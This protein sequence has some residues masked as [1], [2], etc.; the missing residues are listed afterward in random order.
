VRGRAGEMVVTPNDWLHPVCE[1]FI[2]GA[3]EL[4]IPGGPDYNGA[5]QAGV[6]YYQRTIHKGRRVS[7][8]RAFLA[9]AMR[10]PNLDVRTNARAMRVLFDGPVAVGVEYLREGSG[11]RTVVRPRREVILCAGAINTPRL[12]QLSGVGP[13][14]LLRDL[15]IPVVRDLPGV[16]GNLRDH[17]AVRVVA[18]A[19]NARTINQLAR[20]PRLWWEVAKWAAGR[21]SI[22]AVCPSIVHFHWRADGR[23]GRPDIQGVFSPA[24]YRAGRVGVLDAYPGMS[25]GIWQHRPQGRGEVCIRSPDPAQPPRIVAGYLTHEHDRR[26]TL[27]GVRLAR[28]LLATQ[29]LAHYFEAETMPGVQVERDDELLEYIRQVGAS[30]YHL[31]GTARMGPAADP[32]AVVDAALRVHGLQRLRVAD[33]SVFPTTPSANTCAATTMV[34]EKAASMLRM[35]VR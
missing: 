29:A 26:V 32:Q 4:G 21:P 13:A 16:G 6:G 24:S 22:L 19:R 3:G 14:R 25:C 35:P 20:P 27:D 17:Y 18:R 33:A 15:H 5:S 1:A 8:A 23:A 10:R 28:R 31:N 2:R 7:S 30:S 12:L 34:A 9:P 11:E